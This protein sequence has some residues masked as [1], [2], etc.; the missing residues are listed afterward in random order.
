MPLPKKVLLLPYLA[1]VCREHRVA[2][3]IGTMAVAAEAGFEAQTSISRDFEQDKAAWAKNPDAVVM[4][5]AEKTGTSVFD[6][7]EEAISRARDAKADLN[8][9]SE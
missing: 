1:D 2:A 8:W 7:W 9:L 4:A 6:L 5:Y 3:D